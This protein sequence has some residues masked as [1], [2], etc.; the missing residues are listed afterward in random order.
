MDAAIEPKE[1]QTLVG[2]LEK[3]VKTESIEYHAL[4]TRE[5][6]ARKFISLHVV[7][8]GDWTVTRGHQLCEKIEND[9]RG[10]IKNAV[11]FTHLESLDDPASWADIELDRMDFPGHN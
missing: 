6:G 1:K 9:I 10:A 2:V 5:S 11:V 7:V 8:P 4:R 3:Y